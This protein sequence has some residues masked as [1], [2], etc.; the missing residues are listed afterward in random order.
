M[1]ADFNPF[2]LQGKKIIVT[3]ASSGIGRQCAIDCSRMGATV[4]LIARNEDR[5]KETL[6]RMW[7][8][9]HLYVVAD[10]NTIPSDFVQNIVNK[11]GQIDGLIYAAG[12]EKTT[13]MKFTERLDYE[14][15]MNTNA[16][17]ALMLIR[18]LSSRKHL[19][20]GSSIVLISSISSIIARVGLTAYAASKGALNSA[21]KV[22]ALEFAKRKIRVNC[23]LPGT[24]LTSMMQKALAQLSDEDQKKRISDF[25]L[26]LGKA[27]D[28][29][30]ASIYLLS[31]ASR[32]I[33]GQSL[34]IDGGYTAK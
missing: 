18:Q 8:E 5:L 26:G 11:I 4:V 6:E 13:P 32:W 20:E 23:I 28:I 1:T 34:I 16:L 31:D 29:S 2:S 9:G 17:S 19:S 14:L 33:T 7:G 3:G 30:S 15:L 22:L 24:I 12:I 10:I 21:S 27:T 25:P